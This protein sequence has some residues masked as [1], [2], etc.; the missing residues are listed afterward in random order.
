MLL[1]EYDWDEQSQEWV[2]T[3]PRL[4]VPFSEWHARYSFCRFWDATVWH[5]AWHATFPK[6]HHENRLGT[7][8][9]GDL[10][11]PYGRWK[12]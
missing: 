9:N 8:F 6:A 2:I 11:D 10:S 5:A 1:V 4:L 3:G 12:K 7:G